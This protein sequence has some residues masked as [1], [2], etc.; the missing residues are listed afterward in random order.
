MK[1]P[2]LVTLAA[3]VIAALA[4]FTL[5]DDNDSGSKL[6]FTEAMVGAFNI[7][8]GATGELK[9]KKSIKIRGP[10]GMRS[11][12][13]W[14]TT[15]KDLVPEGTTVKKGQF[16]ASLD[17]TELATKIT[18][19][20]SEI[21]QEYTR[22]EQT[23]ID[24]AI[25]MKQ[26]RDD[27]A[28]LKF[29]MAQEELEIEKNKYEPE[30]VIEQSRLKL[31]NSQRSLV[32]LDNKIDLLT[33][34]S[35]AKV[36]EITTNIKQQQNKL[37]Q[38]TDLSAKFTIMAPEDGM[39]IYQSSWDGKKGPGSQISGWDPV[40]AELPDLSQMNSLAYVN[41]V[42]ISKI[43]KG[44]QVEITVDAFPEKTFTGRITSVANI[45]Q[46]LRNQEA[47]VFEINIEIIEQDEVLRP[48]M[49][50]SNLITIFE[51]EE[52]VY[53]PLEA[54][55]SDSVD[56]VIVKKDGNMVKQEVISG[57]SN[58]DNIIIVEG[59]TKGQKLTISPVPNKDEL[60]FI[61]LSEEARR[62]AESKIKAW[63][64]DKKAFDKKNADEVKEEPLESRDFSGGGN[65][66]IVG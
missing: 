44:Q 19:I 6:L 31:K 39:V 54:Y 25:Q 62:N 49:T 21:E 35:Q 63:E 18:D 41:E 15:I 10:E 14:Q 16:V 37:K 64:D 13:V 38:L 24:T 34:Q 56:Y 55:H 58:A 65:F 22:L 8:V 20:Q 2:I 33:V 12:G 45:G 28:N 27:M 57:P 42:D 4:Y 17:K 48:A 26:V 53:I 47:K 32:Q 66:I 50:T 1:R 23:K 7:E 36:K 52:V 61:P 11:A 43:K 5:K 51:Y 40:V 9:A 3:I 30:M 29:S 59:V 46:Q 60:I